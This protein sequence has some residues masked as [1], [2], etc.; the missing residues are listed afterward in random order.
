MGKRQAKCGECGKKHFG[1]LRCEDVVLSVEQFGEHDMAITPG[2]T[3]FAA[4]LQLA[5]EEGGHRIRKDV[6]ILRMPDGRIRVR[7]FESFR[8]H[9]H[10]VDWFFTP[11]E[12]IELNKKVGQ[13]SVAATAIESALKPTPM[14]LNCPKCGAPHYDLDEWATRP[15]STH[16]CLLCGNEWRPAIR[17]T[18]GVMELPS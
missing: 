15:H 2:N 1:V 3:H 10:K 5:R 12:W 13:A 14:L 18:V 7:H 8:Q 17:P 16:Q 6:F 9:I 11:E 4:A